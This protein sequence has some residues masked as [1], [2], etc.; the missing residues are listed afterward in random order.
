MRWSTGPRSLGAVHL[1][2]V[3]TFYIYRYLTNLC[4]IRP[5]SVYAGACKWSI[6]LPENWSDVLK[7]SAIIVLGKQGWSVNGPRKTTPLQGI[8]TFSSRTTIP[9]EG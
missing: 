7:A 8:A 5:V 2:D 3:G 1:H 6:D 9:D 4:P